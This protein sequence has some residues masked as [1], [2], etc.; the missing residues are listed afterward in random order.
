MSLRK[1]RFW[2]GARRVLLC[3]VILAALGGLAGCKSAPEAAPQ[4]IVETTVGAISFSGILPDLG[5]PW[6]I[7]ATQETV[8]DLK[9]LCTGMRN[10]SAYG[11]ST[12]V[13]GNAVPLY[14]A[15]TGEG[16]FA[17]PSFEKNGAY[18][19][20]ITNASGTRYAYNP[21]VVFRDGNALISFEGMTGLSL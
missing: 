1:I 10:C 13:E 17:G 15:V 4:E 3:C 6:A 8:A 21:H 18:T 7:Y 9:D 16:A 5:G 19:V 20:I 12:A 2:Q 14:D 11:A